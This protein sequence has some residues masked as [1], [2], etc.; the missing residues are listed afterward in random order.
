M[1]LVRKADCAGF[2]LFELILSLSLIAIL[3]GFF[4]SR[5][6]YYQ[7]VVEEASMRQ[8]VNMINTSMNLKLADWITKGEQGKFQQ[9]ERR[10]PVDWLA[11]KPVNYVGEL[12]D[13]QTGEAPEGSWYYDLKDGSLVYLVKR[14]A[15]FRGDGHKWIRFHV[16]LNY[17]AKNY[18]GFVGAR[19]VPI[20]PYSWF[21]H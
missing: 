5:M 18:R 16:D 10:N 3:M 7:E 19:L 8:T 2:T 9:L 4:F 20:S 17:N 13:P 15:H 14:S 1:T 11:A 12:Y 21:G 6:L